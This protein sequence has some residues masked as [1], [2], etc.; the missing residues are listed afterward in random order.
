M[1]RYDLPHRYNWGYKK[2]FSNLFGLIRATNTL[3][4]GFIRSV[5]RG[6]KTLSFVCDDLSIYY[7]AHLSSGLESLIKNTR[8]SINVKRII[9]L[10]KLHRI[11]KYNSES[12]YSLKLPEKYVLV[13][14]QVRG[15][16]SVKYGMADK[17]NFDRM[18]TNALYDYPEHKIILKVHPDCLTRKK[19]G[20]FNINDILKNPRIQVVSNN[21]HPVRLIRQS[22][23]IYTVTSQV[24]FEAL[25]WGKKVK[26]F[27]MPFYAGWGLTDDALPALERRTNTSL[28]KLVHAVLVEYPIYFDPETDKPTTVEETI[29]YIGF[30]RQMR[31]RFPRKLYAYGFTPWKKPI[32]KSFTQGSEL[33]FIKRLEEVPPNGSLLVWGSKE[34]NNLDCSIKLIRVEDGFLRSVGLG[35]DL[36]EPQSWVFDQEGIYYDS[37]QSSQLENIFNNC[38]FEV[39]ELERAN[40]L[41]KLITENHISKYN[42]GDTQCVIN[43]NGKEVA[44]VV[45]QVEKDA[46]IR[47]GTGDIDTNLKLLQVVRDK[48]PEAHIIYKPHPDVI[49]GIRKRGVSEAL[50]KNYYDQIVESGDAIALF[51]SVDTI[52]TMTSLVGFEGLLRKK[53]VYTYGMPFYSGWGLTEDLIKIN[54]RKRVLSLSELVYGALIQYPTYISSESKMY[55]S[56]ER[57]IKELIEQKKNGIQRMPLWRK[58]IRDLI[59]LWTHYGFRS[60][61]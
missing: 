37:S 13:I 32:L 15:D 60:N 35:G 18:I 39:K 17:S 20:Y 56:P 49:A 55:T 52:H 25:I 59:K 40:T 38:K 46:S 34:C 47:L 4:D 43:S 11:S 57:I 14:D 5:G 53:K 36:I 23:V 33:I 2:N 42:L 8:S 28:E 29:K 58:F 22:D 31:F 51:D 26:C 61:A 1:K 45:G 3:E 9:E 50:E 41:I 6:S 7:N 44:L 16:L 48:F 21:C 12:E 19:K 27:G 30:Q 54:R 24:G 10:W